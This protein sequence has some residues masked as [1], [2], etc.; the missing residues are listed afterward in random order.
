MQSLD[1]YFLFYLFLFGN[2]FNLFIIK[3]GRLLDYIPSVQSLIVR[4]YTDLSNYPS[5]KSFHSTFSNLH[6]LEISTINN[7]SFHQI[8]ILFQNSFPRL[9][10]LKFFF[11]TDASSQSCL[12]YLDDKRWEFLLRSLI[13]LEHF[14]CCLELPIQSKSINNSFE[15]NQYFLQRNWLFDFHISTYSFNTILRANTKPYPKRRL[16]IMYVCVCIIFVDLFIYLLVP[17]KHLSIIQKII[18]ISVYVIFI[19]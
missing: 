18:F 19:Y 12:D 11:K 16:D 10:I 15:Q 2:A 4:I 14:S 3:I 5:R 6:L 7:I 8:E 1:N 13:S 17:R 9:E